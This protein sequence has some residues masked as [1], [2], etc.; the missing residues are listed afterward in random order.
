MF[1]TQ[2]LNLVAYNKA[3]HGE[4]WAEA[5][6]D[7]NIRRSISD[8]E[9]VPRT[10]ET[11]EKR[12]EKFIEGSHL[13]AAM[14]IRETGEM[15]GWVVSWL[16]N[17]KNRKG[18]F[19]I[20]VLPQFWGRGYASQVIT[21][22]LEYAFDNLGY[23]RMG[24]HVFSGNMRAVE[25]YRR[26]GFKEEGRVRETLYCDGKWQDEILMGLL[27]REWREMKAAEKGEAER[28]N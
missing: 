18:W 24:L 23:H 3:K 4:T 5:L 20:V 15:A 17:A 19:G 25:L 21:W 9:V 22:L 28:S 10:K 8:E 7:I 27:E 11:A 14:E 12:I 1:S 13:W 6:N 2:A 16:D 26:L